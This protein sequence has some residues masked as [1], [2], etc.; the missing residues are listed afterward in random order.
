MSM[1]NKEIGE[2]TVQAYHQGAFKPVSKA[3][4]LGI[5]LLAAVAL[6]LVFGRCAA[7]LAACAAYWLAILEGTRQL[8]G[9]SGDISGFGLTLAELAGAAVLC[10]WG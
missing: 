3:A 9:M 7:P 8:G 10:L 5:I 6:P 1:I 4:V 2:F